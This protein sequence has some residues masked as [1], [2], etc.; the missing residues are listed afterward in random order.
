M[1]RTRHL[2]GGLLVTSGLALL[3]A[4]AGCPTVAPQPAENQVLMRNLAFDPPE[5]TIT[6]GETV[7]WINMDQVDHTATSG[8]P[9]D[10]E[11]GTVFRSPLLGMGESF[12]HTFNEPG[13]FIYFCE[14]HPQIM[15]DAKVI[16][17]AP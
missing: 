5:I 12:S 9:E 7:T 13:E 15:R 3:G 16:V 11:I 17:E 1:R 8:Q 6:A 2:V 14:T 4:S 10:D